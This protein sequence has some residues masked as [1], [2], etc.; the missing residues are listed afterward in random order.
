MG[1]DRSGKIPPVADGCRP[2]GRSFVAVAGRLGVKFALRFQPNAFLAG[3][4][5]NVKVE[6]NPGCSVA[7]LL[8]L[9]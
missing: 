3:Q 1:L 4:I 7:C 8:F 2:P 9:P 5:D 6:Y